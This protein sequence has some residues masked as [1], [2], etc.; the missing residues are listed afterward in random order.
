[1]RSPRAIAHDKFVSPGFAHK[2]RVASCLHAED[3]ERRH[4]S[5]RQHWNQAGKGL[6]KTLIKV[7]W[8]RSQAPDIEPKK[9][10]LEGIKKETQT[11]IKQQVGEKA[12]RM[13]TEVAIIPGALY[14]TTE[15][16]K[17][18]DERGESLSSDDEA[19]RS[20]HFSVVTNSF[21]LPPPAPRLRLELLTCMY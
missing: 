12:W 16:I 1:M 18:Y 3:L 19:R 14:I 17:K 15:S 2:H 7:L 10:Y 4:V 6:R 9:C 20:N 21:T 11:M 5:A 8:K 13:M